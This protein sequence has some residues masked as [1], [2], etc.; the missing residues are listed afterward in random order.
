MG[1]AA[2]PRPVPAGVHWESGRHE[3]TLSP[4]SGCGRIYLWFEEF[5]ACPRLPAMAG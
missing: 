4:A 3:G 5:A 1:R 2:P